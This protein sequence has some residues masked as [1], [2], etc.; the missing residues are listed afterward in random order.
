MFSNNELGESEVAQNPVFTD[1]RPMKDK[2][3]ADELLL[4]LGLCENRSRA[5]A[6]I[7]AGKVKHGT[8][9]VDKASRTFSR[10]TQLTVET[11]LPYVG[12]GGLK[13]ENFLSFSKLEVE[14]LHILDLGASTGGFTDCLLQ[15]G[16]ARATCVDVGHGQ[17]HYKLR[18]DERVT[19]FE[20]TNLRNLDSSLLPLPHY[21]LVVMD[22]SFI[23]LR[24]VLQRAWELVSEQGKL[25]ALIKP[26]FECQKQEADRTKGVIKDNAIRHRILGE[27]DSHM[28]T[29][30]PDATLLH[31][32]EAKPSGTDGNVEF[33]CCWEK[34]SPSP[35]GG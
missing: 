13:M 20:K 30:C 21:P 7:L 27:I 31:Q 3:R 17:L 16:A 9:R 2:L 18:I 19:N 24:K 22:L 5:Q 32:V 8:E 1:L 34:G 25:V 14:G 4:H 6:L 26:Q 11:P 15:K 10:D 29:E 12:R 35:E 23:S 33:F 28:R